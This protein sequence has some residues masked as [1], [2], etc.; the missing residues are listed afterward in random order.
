[1]MQRSKQQAL[2]FLLGAVLVG[3]VLGFSA[4][5]VITVHKRQRTWVQ[6][7][8]LYDE[9][10]V[11]QAQRTRMDSIFDEVGC[12]IEDIMRPVQSS[13][14]SL[15]RKSRVDWLAVMTEA[16]RAQF[17]VLDAQMRARRDSAGK[18]R[19]AAAKD[20]PKNGKPQRQHRCV[21]AGGGDSHTGGMARGSGRP[22]MQSLPERPARPGPGPF[23]W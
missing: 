13:I 15:K 22:G 1:M 2:M 6:R 10:D 18:V 19:A 23:F 11:S 14:D 8:S 16:Q 5:R 4:D 17:D 21:G 9:L 3:G 20:R 7:K 12:Q